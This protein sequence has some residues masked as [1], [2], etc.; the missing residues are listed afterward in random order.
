MIDSADPDSAHTALW[1]DLPHTI[2]SGLTMP[3]ALV[4]AL[5]G[6]PVHQPLIAARA[7]VHDAYTRV[8]PLLEALAA[9][10]PEHVDQESI[11][12]QRWAWACA[13]WYAYS[14]QVQWGEEEDASRA[15]LVP[16]ASLFNHALWP[17][18]VQ[19]GTL[20]R[21]T[22]MRFNTFRSACPGEQLFLGYGA[23]TNAQLLIYY[24]F[25]LPHNP[26]DVLELDVPAGAKAESGELIGA[27]R[28]QALQRLGLSGRYHVT[29]RGVPPAAET[30]A[31]VLAA[32]ASTLE[33][34]IAWEGEGP[35]GLWAQRPPQ[36][37]LFVGVFLQQNN[38]M[39]AAVAGA[40]ATRVALAATCAFEDGKPVASFRGETSGG[41]PRGQGAAR[42]GGGLSSVS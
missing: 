28:A 30:H 19:Y 41:W 14:M 17:H 39:N 16:V 32:D 40:A 24:G 35:V 25:C 31:S 26:Y 36:V 7:H 37:C 22:S 20:H 13:L 23:K 10:H 27:L 11:S 18:I 5:C 9:V 42:A 38:T 4:N 29:P 34:V 1:A 33:A 21:S 15:C 8:Q 6:T 12:P 2:H 3:D